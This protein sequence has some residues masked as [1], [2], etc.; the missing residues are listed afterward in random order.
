[1]YCNKGF[2]QFFLIITPII[3]IGKN[4]IPKKNKPKTVL[5]IF[6]LKH[7]TFGHRLTK[8]ESKVA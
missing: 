1:M 3:R 4:K 8:V 5:A 7:L 2:L 6:F